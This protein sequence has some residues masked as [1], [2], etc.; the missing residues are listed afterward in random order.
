[1]SVAIDQHRHAMRPGGFILFWRTFFLY[2]LLRFVLI[3]LRMF[4][5]IAK[6]HGRRL[7]PPQSPRGPRRN[8]SAPGSLWAQ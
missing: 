4:V 7:P 5:M 8:E 2:Q 6:S 1:M 3:N